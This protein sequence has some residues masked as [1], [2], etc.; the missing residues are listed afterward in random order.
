MARDGSLGNRDLQS[1]E[2]PAD[3]DNGLLAAVGAGSSGAPASR[4][5]TRRRV[6]LSALL[7]VS[8]LALVIDYVRSRRQLD[9]IWAESAHAELHAAGAH[10]GEDVESGALIQVE[11]AATVRLIE[12]LEGAR[13]ESAELQTA[14]ESL[15]AEVERLR[16][17]ESASPRLFELSDAETG[18]PPD[19]EKV[20]GRV[21]VRD[22]ESDWVTVDRGRRDGLEVGDSCRVFLGR[23]ELG[24]FE[25]MEVRDRVASG[26][27]VLA[28]G[29]APA[30]GLEIER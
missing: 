22:L 13:A 23:T 29:R 16:A 6:I 17:G 27:V 1:D 8:T 30:A 24:R 12:Q 3:D 5:R 18:G 2:A 11:D 4:T 15:L 7:F 20:R 9:K 14:N 28:A 21:L 10:A 26:R 25:V 19:A